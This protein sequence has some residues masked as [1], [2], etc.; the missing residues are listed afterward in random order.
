MAATEAA[1]SRVSRDLVNEREATEE[2]VARIC[3]ISES[4]WERV[5]HH[6]A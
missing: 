6:L 5:S 4:N 2:L 1:L 3:D